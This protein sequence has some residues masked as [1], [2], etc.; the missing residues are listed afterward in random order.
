MQKSLEVFLFFCFSGS[1]VHVTCSTIF[2]E[3]YQLFNRTVKQINTK[4]TTDFVKTK[5]QSTCPKQVRLLSLLILPYIITTTYLADRPLLNEFR[6]NVKKQIP[7]LKRHFKIPEQYPPNTSNY[8]QGTRTTLR[9]PW[10]D[11]IPSIRFTR[12]RTRASTVSERDVL[13]VVGSF[14]GSSGRLHR[15]H[16]LSLEANRSQIAPRK[17]TIVAGAYTP[18]GNRSRVRDNK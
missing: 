9:F 16:Q 12:H 7:H 3:P 2:V 14:Q 1:H 17:C 6:I 4:N 11:R 13:R 5:L 15:C 10:S 18:L 8:S